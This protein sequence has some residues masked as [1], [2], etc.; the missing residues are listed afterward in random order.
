MIMKNLFR[1]SGM[2]IAVALVLAIG[3]AFLEI[4]ASTYNGV[5]H[6]LSSIDEKYT[7]VAFISAGEKNYSERIVEMLEDGSEVYKDGSVWLSPEHISSIASNA[8]QIH[9]VDRRV[10]YGAYTPDLSGL[11]SGAVNHLEY[12]SV[13]D[14]YAYSFSV[15]AVRCVSATVTHR[16][17][18]GL[19]AWYEIEFEVLDHVARNPVYDIPNERNDIWISEFIMEKDGTV[20]FKEGETYLIRGFFYDYDVYQFMR[21]KDKDKNEIEYYWERNMGEEWRENENLLVE[22]QRFEFLPIWLPYDPA[23]PFAGIDDNGHVLEIIENFRTMYTETSI[24]NEAGFPYTI[25]TA[26]DGEWPYY[27]QFEGSWQDYLNSEEG[28]VWKEEIIPACQRNWN[29]APFMVTDNIQGLYFFANGD[30]SLLDGRY[31]TQEEYDSGAKVC[32]VS[33]AYA[34]YN[35]LQ[36]GDS[37]LI[38]LYKPAYLTELGTIYTFF[39]HTYFDFTHCFP[40]IEENNLDLQLEYTIVGLYTSPNQP[41]EPNGNNFRPDT[42]FA[43]KAS[44]PGSEQYEDTATPVLNTLILEN[45]SI[46]EF[47]AYMNEHGAAGKFQYFDYGYS[48]M[49]ASLEAMAVNSGRMAMLG[50][51]MFCLGLALFLMLNLRRM[52]PT[53]R[54][55]RLIGVKA[56]SVARQL[57]S[58]LAVMSVAAAVLGTVLCALL[59]DMVCKAVLSQSVELDARSL[60][61]CGCAELAVALV[62]CGITAFAASH[63]NLMGSKRKKK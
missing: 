50:A 41:T 39:N 12:A 4:G 15:Y 13:Y 23:E 61:L 11:S 36:V 26:Q 30:A 20:P 25:V 43:P 59:Y 8:P 46:E 17:S 10:L 1:R 47:E 35:D 21:L 37:V 63:V 38:N 54:G 31:I 16:N 3:I 22:R 49:K 55:M 52:A 27:A 7:T 62:L 5:H 24:K 44:V 29:S 51:A 19:P 58:A 14:E 6:Q 53:V 42:I 18:I 28:R 32:M 57:F 2:T 48:E 56:G 60:L 34:Q 45:G 33:A 9:N 40:I